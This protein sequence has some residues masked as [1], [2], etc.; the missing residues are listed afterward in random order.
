MR[1]SSFVVLDTETTGLRPGRHGLTE[2]YAARTDGFGVVKEEFHSLINPGHPIPSFITSLTGISTAMVKDAPKASEVIDDFSSFVKKDDV[3]VGHNLRFD[4]SF[5]NHARE[6]VGEH[7]FSNP[8]L[9]TLLLARRVFSPSPLASYKL[10][11]LAN[12]FDISSKGAHRA[13]E[14]VH[15]TI[16]VKQALLQKVEACG[17]QE[18]RDLLRLQS[19][20]L[21]K[22]RDLFS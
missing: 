14:D 19:L 18:C 5:L 3:L 1:K 15:M 6:C 10:G 20:P 21:A 7:A 22:A 17:L 4:L 8:S 11:V 12:H 9:C 2:L 16:G 13:K